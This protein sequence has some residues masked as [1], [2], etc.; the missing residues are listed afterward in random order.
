MNL[1]WP[2]ND[3]QLFW[4]TT[5]MEMAKKP[6]CIKCQSDDCNEWMTYDT[7][8]NGP[9]ARLT[10]YQCGTYF[11]ETQQTFMFHIKT[12]LSKIAL[13]L[14]ARTEGMSFHA[15]CRAHT[16]SSGTLKSWETKFEGIKDAWLLYSL[17]H[18]FVEM[19]IEGD[20]LYTKVSKNVPPEDSEGWTISLVERASR[21][22][23]DLRCDKKQKDL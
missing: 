7:K 6:S 5:L 20:E 1:E 3:Y 18:T 14:K 8:S 22:I 19:V 23:W 4:G 10:C 12:P 2:F 21:F 9:R 13:V 16:I 15:T 17:T 11:A